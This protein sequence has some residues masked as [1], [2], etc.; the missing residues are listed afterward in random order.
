VVVVEFLHVDADILQEAFGYV[1]VARR[2]IDG[3]GTAIRYADLTI[4]LELVAFGMAAK[5]VMI[6]EVRRQSRPALRLRIYA[7]YFA[8]R[9]SAPNQMS[10]RSQYN[11]VKGVIFSMS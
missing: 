7:S 9:S 6:V 3:L 5:V 8:R 1:G 11:G 2:R 4:D 10:D